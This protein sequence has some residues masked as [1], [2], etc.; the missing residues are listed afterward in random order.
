MIFE[1]IDLHIN[2]DLLLQHFKTKVLIHE[3]V[4][5]D[6][7]FGGWSVLSSDGKYTDGWQP[8]HRCFIEKDGKQVIDLR[9]AAKM[10]IKSPSEYIKPTEICTGYL[11][12]VIEKI[13]SLGLEPTRARISFLNPN[14]ET[15]WHRDAPDNMY[16]V[17][18]HIPLITNAKCSF[19]TDEGGAHLPADG[20]GYFLRVNRMHKACNKGENIRY[21]LIMNVIDH[22]GIS[23]HHQFSLPLAK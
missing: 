10:G 15:E 1:K 4:R 22:K 2:L 16:N 19:E 9:Q 3:P 7:S 11:N 14:S 6:K 17:R 12:E 13:K 23:K 8:G 18:L 20:S 21:H 5:S